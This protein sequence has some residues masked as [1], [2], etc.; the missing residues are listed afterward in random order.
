MAASAL[1]ALLPS[2]P[3]P[4]ALLFSG[5]ELARELEY[6]EWVFLNRLASQR[7]GRNA[8]V[9]SMQQLGRAKF[10]SRCRVARLKPGFR[11]V[12]GPF[13]DMVVALGRYLLAAGGD[14]NGVYKVIPDVLEHSV[15]AAAAQWGS[16]TAIPRGLWTSLGDIETML[17]RSGSRV[18][19]AND[20]T[21][22]VATEYAAVKRHIEGLREIARLLFQNHVIR[23]N[24]RRL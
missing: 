16:D 7:L 14:W 20:A 19:A 23:S 15:A 8:E 5:Y 3:S 12:V 24:V 9:P 17:R 1:P 6:P 4:D 22:E 11:E 21:P 10:I 13:Y 18:F 2:L